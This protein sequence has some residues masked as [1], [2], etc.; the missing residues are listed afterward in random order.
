[1]I[2]EDPVIRENLVLRAYDGSPVLYLVAYDDTRLLGLFWRN[3]MTIQTPL[4][5]LVGHRR[6]DTK[7]DRRSEVVKLVDAHFDDVWNDPR[8]KYVKLVGQ[9]PEYVEKAAD[10]WT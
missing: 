2:G 6:T 8:T 1:M 10:I 3:R 7:T 5:E 4:L 9:E